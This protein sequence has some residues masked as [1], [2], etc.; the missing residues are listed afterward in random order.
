MVRLMSTKVLQS[1]NM[2]KLMFQSQEIQPIQFVS[3]TLLLEH[4]KNGATSMEKNTFQSHQAVELEELYT[5]TM[6]EQD[7]QVM[8]LLTQWEECTAMF[9]SLAL[10]QFLPM[11]K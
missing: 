6:L 5:Q 4:T 7:L 10:H 11:L 8:D 1:C 9:N 2:K 3:N